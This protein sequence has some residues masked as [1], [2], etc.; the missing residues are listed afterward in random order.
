MKIVLYTQCFENYG[1]H[2][3]SGEG[4][5]PQY[6][7]AKGGSEFQVDRTLSYNE[8]IDAALVKSLVDTAMN[9]INHRNDY[10]EEYVI[11]WELLEDNAPT[12]YEKT[13]MEWEG[14]VAYPR[15]TLA[16]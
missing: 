7:K 8:A 10:F 12:P 15:K 2:D 9:K 16:A 11:D 4:T 6:W 3:W 5:C 14:R 1:A 13:Q